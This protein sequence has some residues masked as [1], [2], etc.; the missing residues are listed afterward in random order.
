[1]SDKIEYDGAKPKSE[2][3]HMVGRECF[4]CGSTN[5]LIHLK[6]CIYGDSVI[7]GTEQT[8]AAGSPNSEHGLPQVERP[9]VRRYDWNTGKEK[10]NG[11]YVMAGEY[12]ALEA[13]LAAATKLADERLKESEGHKAEQDK[14]E[15]MFN[16]AVAERDEL[17]GAMAAQDE[18]ERMA[19]LKCGVRYE[20]AGCDWPDAVAEELIVIRASNAKWVARAEKAELKL[21]SQRA[22]F[23][24]EI[25]SMATLRNEW[26]ARAEA[27]EKLVAAYARNNSQKP[28]GDMNDPVWQQEQRPPVRDMDYHWQNGAK[29]VLKLQA[30][31]L[32]AS[33]DEE[34]AAH[35]RSLAK[36]YEGKLV[37]RDNTKAV[38][39]EIPH[40]LWREI[41][42]EWYSQ[43]RGPIRA[44]LPV[45]E[46]P[47]TNS[48]VGQEEK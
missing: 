15:Q 19:G 26:K 1:M 5:P 37:N 43:H 21:D 28:T 33:L 7:D 20:T 18:R 23:R 25:E 42:E 48:P 29:W 16:T 32:I 38:T 44:A 6:Y 31:K 11:E 4:G 14:W 47:D 3:R 40:S 2:Y 13:A 12:F 27:A 35:K 39:V 22:N 45:A 46:K 36:V 30:D 10:R 9:K 17:K 24:Q 41:Q 8:P 34:I